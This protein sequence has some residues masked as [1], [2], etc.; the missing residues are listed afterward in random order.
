MEPSGAIHP[1]NHARYTRH[2]SPPAAVSHIRPRSRPFPGRPKGGVSGAVVDT[3]ANSVAVAG[4]SLSTARVFVFARPA[5]APPSILAGPGLG[6]FAPHLAT[7][8]FPAT[9]AVEGAQPERP[10]PF[11]SGE[12][13]GSERLCFSPQFG[14]R[15]MHPVRQN[16]T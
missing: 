5:P 8:V 14:P 6:A 1:K 16:T 2:N 15:P 12:A 13:L 7:A 9:A 11:A 3:A 10:C 4:T